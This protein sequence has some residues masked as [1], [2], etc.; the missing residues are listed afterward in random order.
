MPRCLIRKSGCC[1]SL[2]GCLLG[3]SC[4]QQGAKPLA[5]EAAAG[6]ST[7]IGSTWSICPWLG[8]STQRPGIYG[9]DLG[10]TV[11]QPSDGA[12]P[13]QLSILFGDTWAAATDVCSY[14][15][16]K[17]DDFQ[18]VIPGERPDSLRPGAPPSAAADACATLQYTLDQPSDPASWRRIRLYRGPGTRSDDVLLDT[19][20]LR[21]PLTAW[22]DGSHVL[23]AFMR[24]EYTECKSSSDCP[25]QMSCTLDPDYSGKHLGNCQPHLSLT[26]DSSPAFCV[27]DD[28]CAEGASCGDLD[29]GVCVAQEP[30]TVQRDGQSLSPSWYDDDPRRG[31]A[32]NVYLASAFWADRPED[33]ATGFRFATNKFANA[34]VRTVAHFDPA[35]PEHNDYAPGTETLLMWGRPNFVATEGF[36]ALAFLLYQPLDGMLDD[37]GTIHWAPKFFAGFDDAGNV[38]WSEA[39]ADAQPIYGV[40]ENLVRGQDGQWAFDWKQPEFDYVAQMSLTWLGPL[41]RWVM[42]YGGDLPSLALAHPKTGD[43]LPAVHPQALEG[44]IYLRAAAHPWGRSHAGADAKEGWSNAHPVLTRQA[45]AQYLA[46]DDDAPNASDCSKQPDPQTPGKLLGTL[47]NWATQLP[48]DDLL[49]ASA[50]CIA[51][52]AALDVQYSIGGD[53][54]GHLYGASI[55]QEWT[56][57]VTG[58][59]SQLNENEH[60]LELYWNVSTWNPYQVILMKTQLRTRDVE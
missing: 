31:L 57:D 10:I 51:G 38:Q 33:Y 55:I 35:Q 41:Q 60:A 26:S 47:A 43:R 42:L 45:A 40:D 6:D 39:E 13:A 28:D 44:A 25:Q 7:V 27:S 56:A 18:A 52:D 15:V 2:L 36:Q 24:D 16:K 46:C 48:A 17:S 8:P 4:K 12:A 49:S 59:V 14:P 5:P 3:A 19:S 20:M 23:G 9:S 21:T 29:Q 53:S 58:D 50:M 11:A 32:S 22:S 34:S 1:L 37:A 54:G 30:F